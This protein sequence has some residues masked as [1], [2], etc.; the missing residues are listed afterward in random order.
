MYIM[1]I[2]GRFAPGFVA[3]SSKGL[4]RT[5]SDKPLV[6]NDALTHTY[7]PLKM[8]KALKLRPRRC[9]GSEEGSEEGIGPT[10]LIN[11]ACGL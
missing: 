1:Y 10:E 4:A 9:R 5:L 6:P 3:W 8:P 11:A 7:A 2:H